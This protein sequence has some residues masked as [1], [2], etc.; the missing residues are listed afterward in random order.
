MFI[1]AKWYR[2][3]FSRGC[4]KCGHV[5]NW[6][7]VHHDNTYGRC[8]KCNNPQVIEFNAGLQY[9]ILN[10]L[11][12]ELEEEAKNIIPLMVIARLKGAKF[13]L[14]PLPRFIDGY[15]FGDGIKFVYPYPPP[16]ANMPD[17]TR[18]IK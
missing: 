2:K 16:I 1:L 15:D 11:Y 5:V 3:A 13:N 6:R 14:L 4:R 18:K 8:S 9:L 12:L 17:P 10:S 7:I